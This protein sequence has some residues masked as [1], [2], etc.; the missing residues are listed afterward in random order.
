MSSEIILSCTLY[1]LKNQGLQ[2]RPKKAHFC[3]L[4]ILSNTK[5][6]GYNKSIE[7]YP[8]EKGSTICYQ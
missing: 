3:T 7:I 1:L 4:I 2:K 6:K 8:K 5:G